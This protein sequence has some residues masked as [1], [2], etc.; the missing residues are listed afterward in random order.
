M[1]AKQFGHHKNVYQNFLGRGGG[2]YGCLRHVREIRFAVA[3]HVHMKT[4][5]RQWNSPECS[6]NKRYLLPELSNTQVSE[7]SNNQLRIRGFDIRH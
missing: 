5:K 7:R 6:Q 4:N 2:C 1:V 3:W